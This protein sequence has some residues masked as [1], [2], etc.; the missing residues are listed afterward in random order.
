MLTSA[1]LPRPSLTRVSPG[2]ALV[3]SPRSYSASGKRKPLETREFFQRNER[4]VAK[5]TGA[6]SLHYVFLEGLAGSGKGALLERLARI[7]YTTKSLP[8]VKF[9]SAMW[10]TTHFQPTSTTVGMFWLSEWT[11]EL[12][13]LEH[14][15]KKGQK[16]KDNVIFVQRS[17]L[18]LWVHDV[19]RMQPPSHTNVWLRIADEL[20]GQFSTST[21]LCNAEDIK[22]KQRL[23]ER[24]FW[25]EN[26]PKAIRQ[27]LHEED[28]DLQQL[29]ESKY[30]E[31]KEKDWIDDLVM[32]T[33]AK[34]AQAQILTL[35]G[36]DD[37]G[38]LTSNSDPS[39]SL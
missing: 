28:A 11:K 33:S 10:H 32:T 22:L 15:H 30:K 5:R 34:Q 13:L 31:L 12:E 21:I 23:A 9:C 36:L 6:S 17:P 39:S 25:A 1:L 2:R 37:W 38:S 16:H 8:Y 4:L 19:S 27:A 26:E 35:Y 3:D 20:K 18:S 14:A 29:Y 24:M 7:G